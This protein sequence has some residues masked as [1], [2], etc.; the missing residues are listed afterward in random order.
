MILLEMKIP[1]IL[2]KIRTFG[3]WVCAVYSVEQKVNFL[4]NFVNAKFVINCLV[5]L[6]KSLFARFV[7]NASLL[8]KHVNLFKITL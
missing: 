1:Q 5:N 7:F 6:K 2:D 8:N 4:I 3:L